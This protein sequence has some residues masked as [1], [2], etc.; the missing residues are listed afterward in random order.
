MSKWQ[1]RLHYEDDSKILECNSLSMQ[2][3]DAPD[4]VKTYFFQTPS[5]SKT[6]VNLFM[7]NDRTCIEWINGKELVK[8]LK[9]KSKAELSYENGVLKIWVL[10]D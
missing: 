3:F 2:V 5:E 8:S 1:W 9:L 7:Y 10:G 4:G 6:T